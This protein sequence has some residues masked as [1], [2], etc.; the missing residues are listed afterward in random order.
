MVARGLHELLDHQRLRGDDEQRLD[1]PGEL[2]DRVRGDQAERAIHGSLLSTSVRE[3][4][5]G[6]NGAAC[7][8]ATSFARRRS[9]SARNATATSIRLIPATASSKSIRVRRASSERNRSTNCVT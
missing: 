9:S 3:I 8:I 5:M 2:V 1:R 7:S 4:L 6:A